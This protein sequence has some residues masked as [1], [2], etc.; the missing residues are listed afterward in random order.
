MALSIETVNRLLAS[1]RGY[2][3]YVLGIGTT[4]G[5]ISAANYKTLTDSF[6]DVFNGLAL[7]FHGASSI[8]Q[9]GVIVLGPILSIVLAKWSS[10]SAKVTSQAQAVHDAIVDP[11]TPIPPEAKLTVL[12]A[13][14]AVKKI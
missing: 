6:A 8:W 5:V 3:Q 14:S 12:S 13:A 1:G 2:S 4:L 7:V 10:H 11:N 9:I